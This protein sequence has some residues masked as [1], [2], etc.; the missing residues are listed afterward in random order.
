MIISIYSYCRIRSGGPTKFH[1]E[2]T[3]QNARQHL[4]QKHQQRKYMREKL[5]RNTETAAAN[6][7]ENAALETADSQSIDSS[8]SVDVANIGEQMVKLDNLARSR[9]KE[10]EG[11]T[12][13]MNGFEKSNGTKAQ[14]ET[15]L[16]DITVH[17]V[18]TDATV[19]QVP[20]SN[21][22]QNG[23]A[24]QISTAHDETLDDNFEHEY[25]SDKYGRDNGDSNLDSKK[26]I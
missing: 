6:E 1:Q 19:H 7:L 5:I 15:S 21:H 25:P 20:K 2:I 22:N 14:A 24:T 13:D 4:S 12:T 16:E 11:A 18:P 9:N 23:T 17:V 3:I 8:V 10:S 26:I